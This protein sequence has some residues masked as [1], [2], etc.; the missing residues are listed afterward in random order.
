MPQDQT[1]WSTRWPAV[2]VGGSRPIVP[3]RGAQGVVLVLD[4]GRPNLD[5]AGGV[6]GAGAVDTPIPPVA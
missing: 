1:A 4:Q 3:G 6:F 2:E 5:Q